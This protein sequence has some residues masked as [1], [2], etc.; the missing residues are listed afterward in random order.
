MGAPV[1]SGS[2]D[3]LSCRPT[4]PLIWKGFSWTRPATTEVMR[5][6]SAVTPKTNLQTGFA[7]G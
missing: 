1:S 7:S 2:A 6:K 3:S 5:G 4:L